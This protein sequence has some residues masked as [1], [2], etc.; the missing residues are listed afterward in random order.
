MKEV[1]HVLLLL[2]STAFFFGGLFLIATYSHELSL[3]RREKERL[4]WETNMLCN[5]IESLPYEEHGTV[6]EDLCMKNE[7]R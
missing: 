7:R 3:L 5:Y 1:G 6:Y 4:L 2:F